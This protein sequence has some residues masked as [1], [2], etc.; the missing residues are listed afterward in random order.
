MWARNSSMSARPRGQARARRA[1][2]GALIA[3]LA[4]IVVFQNAWLA[5]I[6]IVVAM[7]AAFMARKKP[8]AASGARRSWTA[9]CPK[10]KNKIKSKEVECGNCGA[11]DIQV[12]GGKRP[13]LKC[14]HCE[15]PASN[16]ACP[17]C[18]TVIAA[19]FWR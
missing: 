4:A 13:R 17:K 5:L 1:L 10:C 11:H 9:N 16:P 7:V 19:K 3:A 6:V 18:E 8:A 15:S 14:G 12:V 2:G